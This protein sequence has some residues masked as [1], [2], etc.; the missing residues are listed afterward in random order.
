M[1]NGSVL[2]CGAFKG[3]IN[4]S[5]P[6]GSKRGIKV[7]DGAQGGCHLF[8]VDGGCNDLDGMSKDMLLS[9]LTE[10]L[11]NN[12]IV[13]ISNCPNRFSLALD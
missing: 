5:E 8:I 12:G 4:Y 1:L 7:Y 2:Y 6:G 13:K 11:Y 3:I 9:E 10:L